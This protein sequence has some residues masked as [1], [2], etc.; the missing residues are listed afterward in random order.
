MDRNAIHV[1]VDESK[2]SSSAEISNTHLFIFRLCEALDLPMPQF[3]SE[4]KGDNHYIFEK[5]VKFGA[6]NGRQRRGRIDLYKQ[7][8][9][10]LESKQ[11]AMARRRNA[12]SLAI[13]P[14]APSVPDM[15]PVSLSG[16]AAVS[17]SVLAW[18]RAMSAARIQAE[19]Y[20]LALPKP[21][22]F[23]IILDVGHLMEFY[24]D[25]SGTG[26]FYTPFPAPGR[27]RITMDDLRCNAIQQRLHAVWTDPYS[28]ANEWLHPPVRSDALARYLQDRAAARIRSR[29]EPGVALAPSAG[30]FAPRLG[31][32]ALGTASRILV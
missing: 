29:P 31:V 14:D 9:F 7:G 23:L 1:L 16:D 32:K 13:E 24:A 18:R 27:H 10:V 4:Q 3:A 11:S 19:H 22:P 17:R 6:L 8:C 26:A 20:A 30:R 25:F 12:G 5:T 2:K 28:L 21:P 15:N